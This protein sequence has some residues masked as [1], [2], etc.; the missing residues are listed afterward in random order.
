MPAKND[1]TNSAIL[2]KPSSTTY[3]SGWDRIYLKTPKEWLLICDGS[4]QT[5]DQSDG[6]F[7]E[8]PIT[9]KEFEKWL[10]NHQTTNQTN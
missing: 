5:W 6:Q 10:D 3:R 9:R 4:P 8:S 2:T 7:W 1:I